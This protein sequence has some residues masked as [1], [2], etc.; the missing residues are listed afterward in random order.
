MSKKID[1][2]ALKTRK[3]LK[4]ALAD[5]LL[6]KELRNISIRELTDKADIHRGTF[7]SHY[8]DIYD[9]FEQIENEVFE[10]ISDYVIFDPAHDYKNSFIQLFNFVEENATSFKIL[11]SNSSDNTFHNRFCEFFEKKVTEVCL[12]D[13]DMTIETMP[14]R[15]KHL[16]HYSSSG[17]I[18]LVEMWIQSNFSYPKEDLIQITIEIDSTLDTLY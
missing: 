2:R 15:W 9:L 6:E 11:Y 12:T 7:Y 5:L 8:Q 4:H 13:E 17:F 10:K 14:I 18:S 3:A 1:R 16:I